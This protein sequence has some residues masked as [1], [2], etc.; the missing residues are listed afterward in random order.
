MT[1]AAARDARLNRLWGAACASVGIFLLVWGLS[2]AKAHV[3]DDD[4]HNRCVDPHTA[5]F[6]FEKSCTH[7]DGTTEG[8]NSPLLNGAFYG[9]MAAAT[10]CLTAVFT[11]EA[12]RRR[13]R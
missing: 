1:G 5:T 2:W 7:P 3:L 13:P 9:S 8:T 6:P 12:G 11:I 4:L 10:V